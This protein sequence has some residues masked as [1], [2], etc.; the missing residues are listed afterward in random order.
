LGV[1]HVFRSPHPQRTSDDINTY[2]Y[3]L[4]PRDLSSVWELVLMLAIGLFVTIATAKIMRAQAQGPTSK[5]SDLPQ[6]EAPP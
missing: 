5:K 2:F 6:P 3:F 1:T 4:A